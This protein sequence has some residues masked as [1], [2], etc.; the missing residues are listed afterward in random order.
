MLA[1]CA[2]DLRQLLDELIGRFLSLMELF[3]QR[4]GLCARERIVSRA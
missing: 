4:M 3:L 2:P 1:A